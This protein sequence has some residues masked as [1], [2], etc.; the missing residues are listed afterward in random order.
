MHISIFQE[1]VQLTKPGIIAGNV[2]TAAAGFLL[3]SKGDIDGWLLGATLAG[4]ALVIGSACVFNNYIDRGI[5]RKMARTK[6]RALVS[7]KIA[8]PPAL[9]F[10][11]LLGMTGFALLVLTTNALTVLLGVIAITVYVVLYGLAK[12]RSVLGT[13]VGSIAGALPPMAGYTAVTGRLDAAAV[14]LFLILVCWQ[15]PHFYAIA[16]NRL[17][18]YTAAGLPVLPVKKGQARTRLEILLY[19]HAFIIASAF[20]TLLGYTGLVY[21]AIMLFAGLG[22]LHLAAKGWLNTAKKEWPRDMFLFSLVVIMLFSILLSLESWL[23]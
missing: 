10:A 14:L 20:L 22:W 12:R 15:M 17:S 23:P 3:A 7:G 5:D 8:A 1:H 2:M 19:L 16:L 6:Q 13:L 11:S 4:I 21:L 9:A 18:D